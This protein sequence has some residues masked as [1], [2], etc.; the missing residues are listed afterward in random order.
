MKTNIELN[1]ADK[2]RSPRDTLRVDNAGRVTASTEK[3]GVETGR[4]C[5]LTIRL[6]GKEYDLVKTVS[7]Y[8]GSKS[9]AKF[10]RRVVMNHRLAGFWE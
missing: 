8:Q 5:L 7:M 3:M 1:H 2:N 6:S 10:V 4:M 9:I